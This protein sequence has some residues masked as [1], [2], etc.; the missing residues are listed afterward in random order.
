MRRPAQPPVL[1]GNGRH[2]L[3][4]DEALFTFALVAAFVLLARRVRTAGLYIAI[5]CTS[6]GPVRFLLDFLRVREGANADPRYF[7]LHD[8]GVGPVASGGRARLR[9]LLVAGRVVAEHD[10]IPGLDL[11]ELRHDAQALV[12]QMLNS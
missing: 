2:D 1:P 10:A 3:G 8:I 6:Y 5:M 7:G 11:A 12:Q 9:A 4:F